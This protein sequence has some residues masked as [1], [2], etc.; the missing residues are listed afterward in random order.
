MSVSNNKVLKFLRQK[1]DKMTQSEVEE[2]LSSFG[3]NMPPDGFISDTFLEEEVYPKIQQKNASK[4]TVKTEERSKAMGYGLRDLNA[5]NHWI[6]DVKSSGFKIT[7]PIIIC[8]PGNGAISCEKA[9]GFCKVAERIAGLNHEAEQ[10]NTSYDFV[11]ILGVHYGTDKDTQTAG[12]VT[13]KEIDDFVN[14]LFMPLCTNEKGEALDFEQICTNFSLV[15]FFSHCYGATAVDMTVRNLSDKLIKLGLTNEQVDTALN[16]FCQL[17][18]SPYIDSSPIPTIRIDSFTDSFHKGLDKEYEQTYGHKLDGVELQ[19]DA[20]G[21]F[22]NKPS[23]YKNS[24]EILHILT[25]RLLNT[26]D[27]RDLSKIIDEHTIEYLSREENWNITQ[28]ANNA[29]NANLVSILA[30]YALSWSVT[31]SLTAQTINTPI[32]KTNLNLSVGKDLLDITKMYS[33]NDLKM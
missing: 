21:M 4:V 29:K 10:K 2:Y 8:F 32:Q 19:Y 30:G 33:K 15:T 9:N 7:K 20:P 25:S 22:R 28:K 11:D 27:N 18:Y 3:L 24:K 1:I 31:Q 26:E 12:D 5:Q 17:T 6:E 13:Q 14:H 16:H 23:P